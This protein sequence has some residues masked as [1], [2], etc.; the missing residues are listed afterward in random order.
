MHLEPLESCGKDENGGDNLDD[1]SPIYRAAEDVV[2]GTV[3]NSQSGSRDSTPGDDNGS[4]M[5]PYIAE[6]H[7]HLLQKGIKDNDAVAVDSETERVSDK[8]ECGG[9]NLE[10]FDIDV[11]DLSNKQA[12]E[13][14]LPN[15]VLPLLRYY[16]Y[17]SSESS[18]RYVN[19]TP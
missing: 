11:D 8:G 19:S 4:Q 18:S 13:R 12:E 9:G 6:G 17:E 3:D 2:D 5:E 14:R 10:D 16:Q 1:V 7:I 15:A